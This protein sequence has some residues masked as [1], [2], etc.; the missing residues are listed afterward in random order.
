MLASCPRQSGSG[1]KP[2]KAT[3][4]GALLHPRGM[5]TPAKAFWS[6]QDTSRVHDN[7]CRN[8]TCA[9]LLCYTI[10][11]NKMRAPSI[12]CMHSPWVAGDKPLR[13]LHWR[14]SVQHDKRHECAVCCEVVKLA[15]QL[16]FLKWLV[17]H[18]SCSNPAGATWRTLGWAGW[19]RHAR[20]TGGGRQA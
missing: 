8:N 14:E 9:L 15:R 5:R 11:R 4:L 20:E 6:P 3:T 17:L 19:L 7:T 13:L 10:M 18:N 2:G 16:H 1:P 12:C